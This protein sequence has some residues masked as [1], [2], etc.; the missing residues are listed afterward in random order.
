MPQPQKGQEGCRVGGFGDPLRVQ[1]YGMPVPLQGP[2]SVFPFCPLAWSS[3]ASV[4]S[5]VLIY[6]LCVFIQTCLHW[7]MLL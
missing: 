3:T 4:P 5:A 2:L 1:G 7:L 6:K